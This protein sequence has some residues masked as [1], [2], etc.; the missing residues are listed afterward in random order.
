MGKRPEECLCFNKLEE[1]LEVPEATDELSE[2]L[3]GWDDQIWVGSQI[4]HWIDESSRWYSMGTI[5]AFAKS[6]SDRTLGLLTNMHV[7]I[8]PGQKLFHPLPTGRT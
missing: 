7:G 3:R 4:A 8:E 1:H 2:S 5:G 6:R